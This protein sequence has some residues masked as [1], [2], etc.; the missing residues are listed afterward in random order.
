VL[1]ASLPIAGVDG[2]LSE[3][4]TDGP[5]KGLVLGKTGWIAGVCS[6]S[7]YVLDD[8]GRAAMAFSIL[9]NGVRGGEASLAKAMQDG[10][11][12]ML[13]EAAA[14]GRKQDAVKK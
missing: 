7:G 11:C 6:L 10:I 13:A 2:T 9:A 5:A 14:V 8:Q 3:R 12:G 4:M 1:L